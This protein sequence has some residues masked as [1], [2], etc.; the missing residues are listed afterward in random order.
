MLKFGRVGVGW[1]TTPR[2]VW[3]WVNVSPGSMSG[4]NRYPCRVTKLRSLVAH[5]IREYFFLFLIANS[6]LNGEIT[7]LSNRRGTTDG[8]NNCGLRRWNST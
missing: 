8:R 6:I 5:V 4:F 2:K 7:K 3:F 1:L